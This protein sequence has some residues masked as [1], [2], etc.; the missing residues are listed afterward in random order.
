MVPTEEIT[1]QIL[2]ELTCR[3]SEDE[4]LIADVGKDIEQLES[5]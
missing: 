4:N 1:I 5:S 2:M 3:A